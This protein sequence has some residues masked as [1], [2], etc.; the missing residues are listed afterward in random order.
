M[1]LVKS[2]I[3]PDRASRNLQMIDMAITELTRIL[4]KVTE[5]IEESRKLLPT[6]ERSLREFERLKSRINSKHPDGFE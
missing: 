4:R 1:A 2:E 6:F 5:I 3:V